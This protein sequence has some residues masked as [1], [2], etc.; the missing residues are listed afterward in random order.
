[1]LYILA[2][3]RAH[4]RKREIKKNLLLVN[5]SFH[6]RWMIIRLFSAACAV[7]ADYGNTSL[8]LMDG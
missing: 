4:E 8:A 6:L 3:K 7:V 5:R 2:S 1:M